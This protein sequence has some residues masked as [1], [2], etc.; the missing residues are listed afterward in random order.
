MFH[1]F[2]VISTKEDSL[3]LW[4][5]TKFILVTQGCSGS[6]WIIKRLE[7]RL[8]SSPGPT[9]RFIIQFP[10]IINQELWPMDQKGIVEIWLGSFLSNIGYI[11]CTARHTPMGL[12]F[13]WIAA[14]LSVSAA[15]S[16]VKSSL[17]PPQKHIPEQGCREAYSNIDV[18]VAGHFSLRFWVWSVLK[19]NICLPPFLLK[20]IQ[21]VVSL[22]G[23]PNLKL[24][25]PSGL[26][27]QSTLIVMF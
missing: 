26:L 18:F 15:A 27:M 1:I 25:D 17:M 22:P 16:I 3:D 4:R 24:G 8:R 7:V 6:H 2:W 14:V 20:D 10:W 12:A 23:F 19:F 13:H 9:W 21:A 11:C 5:R